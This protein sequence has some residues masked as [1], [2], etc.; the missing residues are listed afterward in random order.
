MRQMEPLLIQKVNTPLLMLLTT[1]KVLC[2]N[3]PVSGKVER[4]EDV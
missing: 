4:V 3:A 1:V 2:I